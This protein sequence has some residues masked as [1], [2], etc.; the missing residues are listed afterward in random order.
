MTIKSENQLSSIRVAKPADVNPAGT[1]PSLNG[2]SLLH[3]YPDR[4][5]ENHVRAGLISLCDY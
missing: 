3:T 2:S 1:M 5:P 4:A